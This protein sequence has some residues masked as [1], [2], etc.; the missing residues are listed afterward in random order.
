[1]LN[2]L[3]FD[4]FLVCHLLGNSITGPTYFACL[5][6]SLFVIYF[7]AMDSLSLFQCEWNGGDVRDEIRGDIHLRQSHFRWQNQSI[8]LW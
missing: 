1:M 7:G 5:S 4:A 6:H 2:L 3:T 8:S